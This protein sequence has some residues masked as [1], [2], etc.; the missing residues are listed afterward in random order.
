MQSIID[1]DTILGTPV[2]TLKGGT[3][4]LKQC[5][6]AVYHGPSQTWRFPAF[7]PIHQVVLK[8]IL[9]IMP[10]AALSPKVE[11]HLKDQDHYTGIPEDFQF[12]T[13]PFEH[14][15][16]GLE[17]L[18]K[19]L[20]AG[21]F[22]SPGLGKSKVV[23]D[24]HRLTEDPMLILCPRVMLGTWAREFEVHGN[25]S[26][27]LIID[28]TK[29]KKLQLLEQAAT[30]TPSACIVTFDTAKGY[31]EEILRIGYRAMVVDESHYF[32]SPFSQRTKTGQS[33]ARRAYRRVI[34]SG[35]P[36]LGSPS[37]LYG[38]LRFLGQ[39]FCPEHWW[40][41]KKKFFVF[42]PYELKMGKPRTVLGYKNLEIM[43]D[44][45]NRVCV[46]KTKEECLDLPKRLILDH[47]FSI[48]GG[49]KKLYN[50][51]IKDRGDSQGL[52]YEALRLEGEL[53]CETGPELESH[54]I[55]DQPITLLQKLG[56]VGSGFVHATKRN[57]A[58]C[59]GCDHVANCV[60]KAILPYTPQC[61]AKHPDPGHEV[62]LTKQNSRLTACTGLVDTILADDSNKVII[63]AN[64]IAELDH[65]EEMLVKQDIGFVRV[66]GGLKR[67]TLMGYMDRF[68]TDPECRAYIAQVGTGIG[69]TLNAANYMIYYSLPF[70]LDHYLQSIDRNYRVGQDKP[71]TVYRLLGKGSI[72]ETKAVALD[73]KLDI[74]NLLTKRAPCVGCDRMVD[75]QKKG[76]DLY[77]D[78]C[79]YDRKM[80]RTSIDMGTL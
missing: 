61:P 28:G 50:R 44:R 74:S 11:A 58:I 25:V 47:P 54:I 13:T 8:D 40:A 12:V 16:L 48:T 33:L 63:W 7:R 9:T 36:S 66:Q 2:F 35:T 57:P 29:K 46:R 6:G 76:I 4:H 72:D 3:G 45:V 51:L 31:E 37:D 67:E 52:A 24:L 53:N 30:R 23:V 27:T 62:R 5:M 38:Q 77:D 26:D 43:N 10:K 79:K 64:Y 69:I 73:N 21:L 60:K 18:H 17:H 78:D 42:P 80:A 68:N 41:F 75:C 55:C 34:L 39:Y 20:R 59:E 15:R 22:Y 32:K 14:Q 71:V 70:S 49:Q 19:N 65:L 56:Q 1:L